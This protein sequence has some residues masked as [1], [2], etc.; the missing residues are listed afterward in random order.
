MVFATSRFS[1]NAHLMR[2]VPCTFTIVLAHVALEAAR[3][4]M[5][6]K[7]QWKL[8]FLCAHKVQN[9]QLLRVHA[10]LHK[11]TVSHKR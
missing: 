4:S 5:C 1:Y 6:R 2:L 7:K 3:L 8:P 10:T 11:A 9:T